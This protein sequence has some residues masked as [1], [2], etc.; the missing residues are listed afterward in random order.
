M[1]TF[2]H[3]TVINPAFILSTG[4]MRSLDENNDINLR[5]RKTSPLLTE[6]IGKLQTH[7][8]IS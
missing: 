3:E 8:G 5:K 2:G 4:N 6:L 7:F 1:H